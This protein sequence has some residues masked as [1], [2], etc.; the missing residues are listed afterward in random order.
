VW[1]GWPVASVVVVA[2]TTD[3]EFE[4]WHIVALLA[5]T[6]ALS[7]LLMHRGLRILNKYWREQ[8]SA[9]QQAELDTAKMTVRG[10]RVESPIDGYG[11]VLHVAVAKPRGFTAAR[12]RMQVVG[13]A[14]WERLAS[15]VGGQA[16][17]LLPV[18]RRTVLPLDLVEQECFEPTDLRPGVADCTVC[19][20]FGLTGMPHRVKTRT[21]T[22]FLAKMVNL[23]EAERPKNSKPSSSRP[24]QQV[25]EVRVRLEYKGQ[26]GWA[27]LVELAIPIGDALEAIGPPGTTLRLT[28][29]GDAMQHLASD[30][31]KFTG[32][33]QTLG[34]L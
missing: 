31:V 23:P 26:N 3:A 17:L 25:G 6:V 12:V 2:L 21:A 13:D 4:S 34:Q 32:L 20:R 5:L 29:P 28:L 8:L 19:L 27:N 15:V 24:E 1:V 16:R 14:I 10:I 9:A 7:G 30:K 18:L 11:V 33:T 22:K